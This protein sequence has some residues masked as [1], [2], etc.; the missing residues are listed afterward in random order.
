MAEAW[1]IDVYANERAMLWPSDEWYTAKWKKALAKRQTKR[2]VW[3]DFAQLK[4]LWRTAILQ[5]LSFKNEDK[6][7]RWS[8]LSIEIPQRSPR[9]RLLGHRSDDQ[10]V[11]VIVLS[12]KNVAGDD[13]TSKDLPK[14]LTIEDL[15]HRPVQPSNAFSIRGQAGDLA[16]IQDRDEIREKERKLQAER[17][18]ADKDA[19]WGA[20]LPRSR[21]RVLEEPRISQRT[22]E[23]LIPRDDMNRPIEAI[24]PYGQE[25]ANLEAP[26]KPDRRSYRDEV[27]IRETSPAHRERL[28][29]SESRRRERQDDEMFERD[30]YSRGRPMPGSRRYEE[31]DGD[32]VNRERPRSREKRLEEEDIVVRRSKSRERDYSRDNLGF[33]ISPDSRYRDYRGGKGEVI[34]HRRDT[35]RSW[36]RDRLPPPPLPPDSPRED[37]GRNAGGELVFTDDTRQPR[38]K[39]SSQQQQLVIRRKEPEPYR[40]RSFERRRPT[41]DQEIGRPFPE[42]STKPY[43]GSRDIEREEPRRNLTN[44]TFSDMM[45]SRRTTIERPGAPS[46]TP[47]QAIVRR[48]GGTRQVDSYMQDHILDRSIRI[49]PFPP[50]ARQ[51]ERWGHQKPIRRL[52]RSRMYSD[53]EDEDNVRVDYAEKQASSEPK[54]TDEQ[55]IARTLE[56]FT[57]FKSETKPIS[58]FVIPT[59][60]E[61]VALPS[62]IAEATTKTATL[63]DEAGDSAPQAG[64]KRSGEGADSDES[65]RPIFDEVTDNG[66]RIAPGQATGVIV[67][68]PAVMTDEDGP[69]QD[70]RS[71]MVKRRALFADVAESSGNTRKGNISDPERDSDGDLRHEETDGRKTKATRKRLEARRMLREA[72]EMSDEYKEISRKSTT[73]RTPNSRSATVEDTILELEDGNGNRMTV[74]ERARESQILNTQSDAQSEVSSDV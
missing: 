72:D 39:D 53:S 49:R 21:D 59:S 51:Y 63:S 73:R 35:N 10:V 20:L 37:Y 28:H 23:I 11:Q 17:D 44:D 18:A 69:T 4:P 70:V 57:N 60:V 41:I 46:Q 16:N 66:I 8:L 50:N 43:I 65:Q 74:V 31:K 61:S 42:S 48:T 25:V 56:K 15:P 58:S 71:D 32:N 36:S 3:H 33:R 9:T 22:E 26:L 34:F 7:T 27:I 19:R 5:F 52:L 12:R 30:R 13:N 67:E 40:P 55:L 45:L 14:P 47:D 62:V 6:A 64:H 2:D 68:E 54:L 1:L 38:H 24:R 29:D